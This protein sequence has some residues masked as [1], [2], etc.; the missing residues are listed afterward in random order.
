MKT[1]Q[2]ITEIKSFPLIKA[3]KLFLKYAMEFPKF[4]KF[5]LLDTFSLGDAQYFHILVRR[6]RRAIRVLYAEHSK[7]RTVLA[8]R[9]ALLNARHMTCSAYGLWH[10]RQIA[11][12]SIARLVRLILAR[13]G[14][15]EKS[16]RNIKTWIL[17]WANVQTLLLF[18]LVLFSMQF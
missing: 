3:N 5:P 18:H 6:S 9:T 12:D 16:L 10:A 13:C 8:C 2:I 7:N 15:V 17:L 14:C 11:L 1:H 4:P